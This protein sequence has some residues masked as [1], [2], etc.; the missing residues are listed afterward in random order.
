M[1]DYED[2]FPPADYDV[3]FPEVAEQCALLR[4]L[5]V[6][7]IILEWTCPRCGERVSCEVKRL[8]DAHH[9]LTFNVLYQHA[10]R[11]DHSR[12]GQVVRAI[13][14][15]F[16]VIGLSKIDADFS[17]ETVEDFSANLRN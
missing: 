17:I 13:D 12:C 14:T 3:P 4:D 7:V 10:E 11:E 15:K 16:A 9:T 2:R 5:G 1:P 6:S 8:D